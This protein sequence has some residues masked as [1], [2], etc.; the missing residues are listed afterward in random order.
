MAT[1]IIILHAD[2]LR[3]ANADFIPYA[4]KFSRTMVA[5]TKNS[6][7]FGEEIRISA[8]LRIER[9]EFLTTRLHRN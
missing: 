2:I 9:E 6:R 1:K 7:L 5:V 3:N 4:I 8:N